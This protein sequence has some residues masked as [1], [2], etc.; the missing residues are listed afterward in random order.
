M[1]CLLGVVL[2]A[3]D[4]R[5]TGRARPPVAAREAAIEAFESASRGPAARW[6]PPEALRAAD[7]ALR[8]TF[9]E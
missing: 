2:V 4:L 7:G 3:A 1:A 5:V 9:L 6:A 8:A